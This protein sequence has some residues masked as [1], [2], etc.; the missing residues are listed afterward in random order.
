MRVWYQLWKW[1]LKNDDISKTSC[2]ANKL[3]L[4]STITLVLKGPGP[5]PDWKFPD[6]DRTGPDPDRT[7]VLVRFKSGFLGVLILKPLKIMHRSLI[8]GGFLYKW[9]FCNQLLTPIV[10]NRSYFPKWKGSVNVLFEQLF[11][12]PEKEEFTEWWKIGHLHVKC[13]AHFS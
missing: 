6:P 5:G 8:Q 11:C 12:Y 4:C 2:Y 7:Q 9:W 13:D 10:N 1:F 3:L